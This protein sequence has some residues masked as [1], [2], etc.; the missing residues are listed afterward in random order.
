MKATAVIPAFNEAT[1]II[2]VLDAISAAELVDEVIVVDD[3][4]RDNTAEVAAS[5]NGALVAQLPRNSG[6][7]GAMCAGARR[8]T[9]RVVVFLDADLLHLTPQHVDA[10]VEPV[11]AGEA[12]MTVGQFWSGSPFIT[13]WMRFCPAISGQRAMR[14]A[15]FLA[16]PDLP[17]AGFGVEVVI[18]RYAA[19]RRLRTRYVHLPKITHV[20][21][22]KKRGVVRG[23]C[24]RATM[25]G[26][27]FACM[28]R[29]GYETLSHRR[30]GD[31]PG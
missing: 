27:I 19:A 28:F 3:G 4:S 11:L 6:K 17:S 30:D 24:D 7:A 16:I 31:E 13:A 23:V 12:D 26:Q 5:H 22:E 21:K 9:N 18:T 25:Y 15:D 10:L 8:A 20:V 2:S 29:N 1:R 14:T